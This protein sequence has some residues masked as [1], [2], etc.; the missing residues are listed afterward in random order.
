MGSVKTRLALL[1]LVVAF[2]MTALPAFAAEV[3]GPVP[4]Q[5]FVQGHELTGLEPDAAR[6]L[7]ASATPLPGLSP[8]TFTAAGKTFTFTT[9]TALAVNVE[10]MLAEAYEDTTTVGFDIDPVYSIKGTVISS[11]VNARKASVYR[12]PVN[13]RYVARNSRMVVKGSRSGRMLAVAGSRTVV[14]NAVNQALKTGAS[15]TG[16][17]ALKTASITPKITKSK[18][19]KVIHI[20]LSE[21][22]LR[23]YNKGK[24][25]KKYRVAIGTPGH[26]TPRGSFKITA[27]RKNPT[28]GNPGSAWASNMPSFIGPGPNNPLGTRAMNLNVSGIRIHGTSKRYSIGTAASHGCVRMLREDVENLFKRVSVGTPVHIVK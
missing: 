21:R 13:A 27:K 26:P 8:I 19:G 20:D 10:A 9:R 16:S 6:A 3:S 25:A 15:P 14:T 7:I 4:N 23:L 12:A 18:L 22:R 2:A 11:W 24:L 28:W 1:I 5:C 17:L